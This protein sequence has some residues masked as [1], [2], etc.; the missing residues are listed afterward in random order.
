MYKVILILDQFFLKYE[1]GGQIDNTP[2]PSPPS[3]KT[4]LKN[5]SLI[6]VKASPNI[7][8]LSV[9]E[10]WRNI[11]LLT[12]FFSSLSFIHGSFHLSHT[13]WL[14]SPSQLTILPKI[15]LAIASKMFDKFT[16]GHK[17]KH[18]INYGFMNHFWCFRNYEIFQVL[19]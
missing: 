6:K 2:P 3:E 9:L 15:Y 4:N 8:V 12:N 1:V 18:C 11:L 5:P 16:W 10:L 19:H 13:K 7:M 17:K 14:V